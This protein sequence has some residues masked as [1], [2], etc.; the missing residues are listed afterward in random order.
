MEGFTK[1]PKMQHFKE[2]GSVQRKIAK[3]EKR[4]RKTE[5]KADEAQDK[6]IVKKAFKQ[7]DKAE[8]GKSEAT[9]I[10]LKKGGR[11]K[12]DC[13]TVKKFCGG[14][15]A[16]KEGGS[17]ENVYGAKKKSGDLDRIE[18]TK[19]IKPGKATAPSKAAVKPSFAGSDVAKEKS[20]PSGHEDS[21]IKSKQSGK[22]A[23][24]PSGA[25]GPDP[26]KKGGKVKKYD[27][28]GSVFTDLKNKI[29]G[30]PKQ[31]ADALANEKK[32]LEAKQLQRAAGKPMGVTEQLATGLAGAGQ[33][34]QGQGAVSDAERA[35]VPNQKKGGKVKKMNTGGTC[36]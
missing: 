18:K 21:Y 28:G 32:Y 2:G 23:A 16:Y 11:A 14:G 3:Y 12:K 26:F 34:M 1:L 17:V 20:K 4:E 25:K 7:H 9:E 24:A 36:S 19:D 5:E 30:T 13:G 6:A 10:K 29:M 8:H 22:A 15:N 27:G 33:A 31:N 35:A